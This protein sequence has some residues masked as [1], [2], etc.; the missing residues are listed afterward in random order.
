MY[1]KSGIGAKILAVD[2][3]ALKFDGHRAGWNTPEEVAVKSI[4]HSFEMRQM[5][6]DIYK[7]LLPVVGGKRMVSLAEQILV[8]RRK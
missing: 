6:A 8:I 2:P 1:V 7:I 3:D 4:S 5:K